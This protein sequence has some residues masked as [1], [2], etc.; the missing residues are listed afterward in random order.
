[1]MKITL[2][3]SAGDQSTLWIYP[4]SK[5]SAIDLYSAKYDYRRFQTVLL[6]V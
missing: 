3:W 4:V 1:M 6:T 2:M 5:L